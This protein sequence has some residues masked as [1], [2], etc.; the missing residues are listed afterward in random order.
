MLPLSVIAKERSDC[1]N[2]ES[3]GNTRGLDCHASLVGGEV[4]VDGGIRALCAADAAW[5]LTRPLPQGERSIVGK[6]L[7]HRVN[8][9][10][11]RLILWPHAIIS[12]DIFPADGAALVDHQR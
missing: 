3:G 12:R 4:E 5:P 10:Q 7:F 2:P 6:A 9:S 8:R 11:D 1:G